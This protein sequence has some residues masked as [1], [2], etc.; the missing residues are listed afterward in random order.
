MKV[1]IDEIKKVAVE[2][3]NDVDIWEVIKEAKELYK[4][5]KLVGKENVTVTYRRD[6]MEYEE[7]LTESSKRVRAL[8]AFIVLNFMHMRDSTTSISRLEEHFG[9]FFESTVGYR[10][11]E[12]TIKVSEKSIQE[13][14][15]EYIGGKELE[16][17]YKEVPVKN[18]YKLIVKEDGNIDIL[19]MWSEIENLYESI[20]AVGLENTTIWL[21]N[22]PKTTFTGHNIPKR[23]LAFTMFGAIIMYRLGKSN[24]RAGEYQ[25]DDD[26]R[27][28]L[29]RQKFGLEISI[30]TILGDTDIFMDSKDDMKCLSLASFVS[31]Y[32]KKDQYVCKFPE[33]PMRMQVLYNSIE[34]KNKDTSEETILQLWDGLDAL[35]KI[36]KLI[37]VD[38]AN[39]YYNS[40]DEYVYTEA[41]KLS[42]RIRAFCEEAVIYM[43]RMEDSDEDRARLGVHLGL[44]ATSKIILGDTNV[45]KCN[46]SMPCI[47][48]KELFERYLEV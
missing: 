32:L 16:K 6:L 24:L 47:P 7:K 3:R 42:P 1:A 33:N 37:G 45:V 30:E 29:L 20:M 40:K 46:A 44:E 26:T 8:A 9:I 22:L 14:I 15:E 27:V 48:L 10:F 39:V 17:H 35:Y 19:S 11:K 2:Y 5:V 4:A 41:V 36:S 31:R 18:L 38:Y 13:L 12:K 25:I 28:R 34:R 21:G 23:L 43:Y